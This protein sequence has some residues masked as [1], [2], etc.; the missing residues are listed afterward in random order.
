MASNHVT[1]PFGFGFKYRF[2]NDVSVG[3][4]WSMRKTFNDTIDGLLNV[5]LEEALSPVHNNDWYSFVGVYL[6][7]R[8]WEKAYICHGVY[9]QKT[10]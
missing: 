9:E 10:Y 7:I 1:V 5:G 2:K 6:T 4:E 3:C 8:I